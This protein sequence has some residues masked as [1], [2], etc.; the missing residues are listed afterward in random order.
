[1]APIVH[2]T[3][4]DLRCGRQTWRVVAMLSVAAFIITIAVRF[5]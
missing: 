1:M 3:L 4:D 5:A 2:E